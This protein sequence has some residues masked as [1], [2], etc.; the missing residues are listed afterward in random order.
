[1]RGPGT[2]KVN[3]LELG[4]LHLKV[5]KHMEKIIRDPDILLPPH[6]SYASGSMDGKPWKDPEAINAI[7][8]LAPSLP[9][10]K[11]VLVAFFEGALMTWKRFTAEFQEGGLIDQASADEKEQAWMPPTNDVNEGAL[12]ALRSYLRKKPN[13]TMHYYNAL[14]MFKFNRT[15]VFAHHIFVSEDHAYIRQEARRR[16]NSHLEKARKAAIM[17]SKEKQ[18]TEKRVKVAMRDQKRAQE[19]A[20]LMGIE[21][22]TELEYVTTDMTVAQLRDQ[23]EAYRCLVDGIPL[24]SHLKI[25]AV[26]IDALKDAIQKYKEMCT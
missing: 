9:H 3:M 24:K 17:A 15:G 11:P 26:M 10:L 13:T 2:E 25:K 4:P 7:A 14:A 19:E 18:V 5:Q 20:R 1:V 12:G 16:D 8:H 6:G 22:I 23:L 21:L